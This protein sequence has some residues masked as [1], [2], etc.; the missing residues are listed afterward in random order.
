[1]EQKFRGNF[2]ELKDK[3]KS[4]FPTDDWVDLSENH[5]QFKH[6]NGATINW[7]P[8]TGTITLQGKS[9]AV[10]IIQPIV[11]DLLSG[12]E[13]KDEI[14]VEDVPDVE[15]DTPESQ[16]FP[17]FD[18]LL[19]HKYSTTE[20]IIGIVSTVGTDYK[21]VVSYLTERLKLHN[22]ETDEISISHSVIKKLEQPEQELD[23]E[24]KRIKAYM[25]LGNKFRKNTKDNSILALGVASE[26]FHKREKD[27]KDGVK[28]KNKVAYIIN[29]LKHPDEVERLREIYMGGF[30]LI[31][32][33]EDENRRVKYLQDEKG[34]TKEEG[35]EIISQDYDERKGHGQHTRDTFQLSD[36]FV[37]IDGNSDRLK[38]D[39]QRI[40]A[41]IFG[42]PYVTPTFDEFSMFMAF[43]SALRSADLS[44]QVG[45]V[46]A[47]NNEIIATGANDCPKAYGGLYWPSYDKNQN[48]LIDK[49]DGRDY[50][51]GQD[52][53]EIEKKKII[54]NI[55]S[56]LPEAV[57]AE[58][59]KK[60]LLKSPLKH[61]TEF[62]RIVHAEMEALLFC[63]R[64]NI[65]TRKAHLYCTTFP[66]HNCAKHIIAAGIEK[67]IYVE[68]YPKS[69]AFE[70][71]SDAISSKEDSSEQV[72]FV[73]FV[74]VG[75]RKF[76]D[77]FSMNL[78][79]GYPLRRKDKDGLTIS[80]KPDNSK[81]RVQMLPCS[82]L[83]KE[84]V[85]TSL[86]KKLGDENDKD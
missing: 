9:S 81:A 36:F 11:K 57:D 43:S 77:F 33:T 61:I 41:L 47:K 74:G 12:K 37:N 51:R 14:S 26:I 40:L 75:P 17:Y 63:A 5:K 86:F 52:S 18:K 32:I 54:D 31:G 60:A 19:G 39:I 76:F 13:V 80:W 34:M 44:R 38:N 22:Y 23:S 58:A 83:E 28:P 24:F 29:S 84:T 15:I 78:S 72:I 10:D 73:P 67:V 6:T 21:T 16:N 68:P 45:A 3:L 64:N 25:A 62:G 55:L 7:Y 27:D 42:H 46:I 66:C 85:A 56:D 20:I 79:H 65:S 82:Y 4:H 35:E 30:Y 50:M 2:D 1:M 48:K 59:V 69:K 8:S 71:Y 70:F 49:L 53:N